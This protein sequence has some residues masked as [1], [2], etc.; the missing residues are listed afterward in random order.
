MS[1]R[2][3]TWKRRRRITAASSALR[4]WRGESRCASTRTQAGC[5]QTADCSLTRSLGLFA[6]P[7]RRSDPAHASKSRQSV[8]ASI[9]ESGGGRC[10]RLTRICRSANAGSRGVVLGRP[11]ARLD[12]SILHGAEARQKLGE[13]AG[14]LG[15]KVRGVGWCAWG[16]SLRR[17]APPCLRRQPVPSWNWSRKT[18]DRA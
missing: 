12:N 18:S 2:D 15:S 17:R 11:T 3:M 6:V 4:K 9:A 1:L 7:K 8:G 10:G 13:R 5:D 16:A 14:A